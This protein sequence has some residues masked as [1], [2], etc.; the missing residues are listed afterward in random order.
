M[1]HHAGMDSIVLS[2]LAPAWAEDLVGANFAGVRATPAGF[3]LV[4]DRAPDGAR[5]GRRSAL[6]VRL[7]PP[8]WAWTGPAAAGEA[9]GTWA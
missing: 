8:V 6:W 4:F 2:Q 9:Q 3:E 7:A 1:P 5:P